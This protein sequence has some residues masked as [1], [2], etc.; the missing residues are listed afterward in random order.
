MQKL[1]HTTFYAWLKGEKKENF[2]HYFARLNCLTFLN[3][4]KNV[5]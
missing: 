4:D 3:N 5:E 1:T 2:F